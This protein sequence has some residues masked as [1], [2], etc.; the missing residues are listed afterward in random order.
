M[1]R[2]AQ[3]LQT[4]VFSADVSVGSF[5]DFNPVTSTVFYIDENGMLVI[6]DPFEDFTFT[7]DICCTEFSLHCEKCIVSGR[8]CFG[9]PFA[10]DHV[11]LICIGSDPSSS[12]VPSLRNGSEIF[13]G[14]T[15][16]M[17]SN[18]I[19]VTSDDTFCLD[20]PV[21]GNAEGLV[22]HDA[23]QINGEP[24]LVYQNWILQQHFGEWSIQFR[25][26]VPKDD[27]WGKVTVDPF[28]VLSCADPI[29]GWQIV[30][31]AVPFGRWNTI[32]CN[33]TPDEVRLVLNGVHVNSASRA[34]D[35]TGILHAGSDH[36]PSFLIEA[37]RVRGR[38]LTEEEICQASF[39]NVLSIAVTHVDLLHSSV[40]WKARDDAVAY[41][42]DVFKNGAP[43]CSRRDLADTHLVLC[44]FDAENA[45]KII[46]SC[47]SDGIHY[48]PDDRYA[49]LVFQ[50]DPEGIPLAS[51]LMALKVGDLGDVDLHIDRVK[52]G[53]R[54]QFRGG[55]A[56]VV[57]AD[58]HVSVIDD[59]QNLVLP[60]SEHGPDVQETSISYRG[61]VTKIAYSSV[62]RSVII[63][64][65]SYSVNERVVLFG[66]RFRL[67]DLL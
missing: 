20:V 59:L 41:G 43:W 3:N 14:C 1:S 30:A 52:D 61:I 39:V 12:L 47:T 23:L 33:F 51:S 27:S 62:S 7:T 17:E 44:S 34:G 29:C 21:I 25:I 26:F 4:L 58:P 56:R 48:K 6:H 10:F 46:L 40:E 49:P 54:V 16:T 5:V 24:Q 22:G 45:Y 36:C 50:Y 28:A 57:A 15:F 63:D 11:N 55:V 67:R 13:N 37:I 64:D 18:D 2:A 65:T 31:T 19:F 38:S 42:L 8:D 66:K 53:G 32:C 35:S 9:K 60:F